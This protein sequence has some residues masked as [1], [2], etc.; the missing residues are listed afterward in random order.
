MRP[1]V[2]AVAADVRTVSSELERM[3]SP[4]GAIRPGVPGTPEEEAG[5]VELQKPEIHLQ[6]PSGVLGSLC[7]W[8]HARG[9]TR[10]IGPVKPRTVPFL[11]R[12]EAAYDRPSACAQRKGGW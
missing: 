7:D 9:R 12:E 10:R 8:S 5:R 2:R 4:P 6:P 11:P 3:V 1:V